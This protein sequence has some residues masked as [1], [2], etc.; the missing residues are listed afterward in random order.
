[1][2]G[3]QYVANVS[4]APSSDAL[5]LRVENLPTSEEANAS[6][7]EVGVVDPFG[8]SGDIDIEEDSTIIHPTK[9]S[10]VNFGKSKFK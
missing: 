9:Q 1:M 2:P 4:L 3:E 6:Q 7:A 10:H 8:D 5:E